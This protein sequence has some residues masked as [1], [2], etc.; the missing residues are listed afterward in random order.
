MWPRFN[1]QQKITHFEVPMIN[2]EAIRTAE[3]Y[4][5]LMAYS[6]PANEQFAFNEA[7]NA[8]ATG[9]AAIWP[10]AY[11]NLWPISFRVEKN[12][13]GA[14]LAVAQ[15]PEDTPITEPMPLQS[16]MTA[17]THKQ[18]IGSLNIWEPMKHSMP[19]PL[20]R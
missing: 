16:A 15:V 19:M 11:N 6:V 10:F 8:I 17:R 3:I 20:G 14:R 1:N 2:H 13:P 4:R 7:A 12:I 5:K 18:P 9:Q